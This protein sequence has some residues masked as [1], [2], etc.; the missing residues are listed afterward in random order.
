MRWPSTPAPR[1]AP[2]LCVGVGVG[3][4]IRSRGLGLLVHRLISLV[5][6]TMYNR[7]DMYNKDAHQVGGQTIGGKHACIHTDTYT[8]TYIHTYIYIYILCVYIYIN[9]IID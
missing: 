7:R 6:H 1:A 8:Y 4:M 3:G 5:R 2:V 9:Q